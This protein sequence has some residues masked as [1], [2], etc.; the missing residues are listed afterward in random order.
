[1][2]QIL[3]AN[4]KLKRLDIELQEY[5]DFKGQYGGKIHFVNNDNDAFIFRLTAEDTAK[6][7]NLVSEKLVQSAS[8]LGDKLLASLNLLPAPKT[9][10]I[11]PQPE[12]IKQDKPDEEFPVVD[13]PF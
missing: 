13:L 2:T 7:I 5:G 10:E 6:Y 1:M 9:L 4:W 3:G 8:H 11:D 12:P